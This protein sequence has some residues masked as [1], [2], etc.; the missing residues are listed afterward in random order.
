MAS[1]SSRT[2]QLISRAESYSG[3]QAGV[4]SLADVLKGPSYKAP[5]SPENRRLQD[6]A[7]HRGHWPSKAQTVLVLGM[8]HPENEPRLDYWERGDTAGNRYLRELSSSL[9]RWLRET[10]GVAAYPLP[11]HLEKGGLFLKD[12]AVLAGIGIVGRNNLIINPKWGPRLRLRSILL[13]GDWQM[14]EA[15]EGFTP[16]DKCRG[17]CHTACPVKAFLNG[18]YHRSICEKQ[19]NIDIE[20]SVPEGAI[21]ENGQPASVITYCRACELACPIGMDRSDQ[22]A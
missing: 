3:I 9:K 18:K 11:Y 20:N 21:G 8:H 16:C 6:G 1:R 13:E 2:Q 22:P 12:A 15:L 4:A 14:T 17:F 7:A 19:M 10:C 5:E